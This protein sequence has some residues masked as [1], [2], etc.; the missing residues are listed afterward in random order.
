MLDLRSTTASPP[1]APTHPRRAP[2]I[3]SVQ[4]RSRTRGYVASFWATLRQSLPV[5]PLKIRPSRLTLS[6]RELWET[7][8]RGKGNVSLAPVLLYPAT[9]L[10]SSLIYPNQIG[11]TVPDIG[12]YLATEPGS[13]GRIHRA[14]T[15]LFLA[16]T[17]PFPSATQAGL[18][19]R[20]RLQETV[21]RIGIGIANQS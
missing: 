17:I 21:S 1:R 13:S 5:Q 20:L 4:N 18:F 19:L 2:F 3:T 8:H 7:T 9:Q 10:D 15:L 11:C 14:N 16:I 6:T 12:V